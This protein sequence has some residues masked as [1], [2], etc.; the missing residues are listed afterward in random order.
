[1]R[2]LMISDKSIFGEGLSSLLARCS[3]FELMG[4][5]V[6]MKE[7]AAYI[8]MLR[9]DVLILDRPD[10]EADPQPPLMRC[11]NNGW[12]QKIVTVSRQ[13]NSVC[14]ITSQRRAVEEVGSL[15]EAI[16]GL[17]S[18]ESLAAQTAGAAADPGYDPAGRCCSERC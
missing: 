18:G 4:H 17:A 7:V 13:D 15:V 2:I 14:V 12:V 8:E 6:D 3:E 1:M 5:L 10:D 11:L 16:T 9:P